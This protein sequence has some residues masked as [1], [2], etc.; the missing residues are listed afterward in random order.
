MACYYKVF[1]I[2][3]LS[4]SVAFVCK[5]NFDYRIANL[6]PQ[7]H[8][9]FFHSRILCGVDK[10]RTQETHRSTHSLLDVNESLSVQ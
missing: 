8:N 2:I 9:V 1:E 3:L 10:T 6:K 7:G 5:V 4:S